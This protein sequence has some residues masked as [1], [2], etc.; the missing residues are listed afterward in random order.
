MYTEGEPNKT[1]EKI[2]KGKVKNQDHGVQLKDGELVP[3]L[4]PDIRNGHQC[5]NVS[6]SP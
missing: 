5:N 4:D 2:T 3:V 6:N 1:I